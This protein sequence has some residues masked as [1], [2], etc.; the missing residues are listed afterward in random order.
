M[1]QQKVRVVRS[2]M[3]LVALVC[4]VAIAVPVGAQTADASLRGYVR[5]DQGL[6]LPGVTMTATSDAL[7]APVVAVSDSEGLYRLLNLPPGD[8]TIT[9]ELPGFST[10]VREG[11]FMRAGLT[12]TVD[13]ELAIG[14]LEETIIV[15]GESP[16]IETAAPPAC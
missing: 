2:A 14:A 10:F 4:A 7:L 6:V 16:M 9:A 3:A 12:F 15:S 5:D 11:I 13:I 1:L 8:Y